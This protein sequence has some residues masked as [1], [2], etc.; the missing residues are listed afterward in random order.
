ML[1]PYELKTEKAVSIYSKYVEDYKVKYKDIY[2]KIITEQEN[3]Y[4]FL[5][6]LIP[7]Y[8]SYIMSKYHLDLNTY[9]T[10]ASEIR[11]FINQYK[12]DNKFN[13]KD[14]ILISQYLY[15]TYYD[16]LIRNKLKKLEN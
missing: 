11:K 8:H 4:D 6:K 9:N 10:K 16:K 14:F 5:H 12:T 2:K 15:Y 7:K 1:L 3:Y 13:Q